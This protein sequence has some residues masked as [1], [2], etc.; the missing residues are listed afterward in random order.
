MATG[1][2]TST[3]KV[4]PIVGGAAGAAAG[5]AALAGAAV[6][7]AKK[8]G[9]SDV[10]SSNAERTDTPFSSNAQDNPTYHGSA[11]SDENPVYS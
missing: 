8:F 1:E 2:N 5:V 11:V 3:S 9:S 6:L 7:L 10:G 4:G